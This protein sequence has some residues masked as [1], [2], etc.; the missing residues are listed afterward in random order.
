MKEHRL[1][2]P[3][4]ILYRQFSAAKLVNL[5]GFLGQRLSEKAK[6]KGEP[7]ILWPWPAYPFGY[8]DFE[9]W[10]AARYPYW[11]DYYRKNETL[12]KEMARAASA[13]GLG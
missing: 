12:I 5:L 10:V 6:N 3:R 7:A 8:P 11:L 9:S 4:D 2:D 13:A 1:L